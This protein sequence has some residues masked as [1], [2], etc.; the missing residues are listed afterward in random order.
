MKEE[1]AAE[2]ALLALGQIAADEPALAR[3]MSETGIGAESLANAVREPE[4]LGA[5]LDFLFAD[6][7]L[8]LA[9]C[10]QQRLTPNQ[11]I[12]ARAAL[13]GGVGDWA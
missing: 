6:E 2:V 5:V 9:F 1:E 3:L 4:L 11:V 13:P 8:F 10:R 7:P 12:R